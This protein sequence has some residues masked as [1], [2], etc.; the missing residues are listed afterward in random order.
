M[1]ELRSGSPE[2]AGMRPE[3]IELIRE[4]GAQWVSAGNSQ[5]LAVL[6]ARRGVICLQGA[7]G[8]LTGAPHAPRA[9]PDAMFY[10]ASLVKPVTAAIAMMLVEEG[11][12]GLT[13]PVE[14]YIPEV[15]GEGGEDVLVQHL[16][17]HTSGIDEERAATL[18]AKRLAEGVDPGECPTNQHPRM[19]RQLGALYPI[20]LETPPGAAMSYAYQ[21][22]ELLGEVIRRVAG[23]PLVELFQR[24]IFGP[25][26]MGQTTLGLNAADEVRLAFDFDQPHFPRAFSGDGFREAFAVPNPAGCLFGNAQDYARFAQMLLNGGCYGETRLL[27]RASVAQM[28]RNQIPGIGTSIMGKRYPEASWSYGLGITQTE[29]WRWFDATLT[30][31]GCYGHSGMGGTH[32]WVDPIHDIVGVYLSTGLRFDSERQERHRDL[33]LFQNLVTAAVED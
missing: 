19:H 18:S 25:L 7:W 13:R 11:G 12:L 14:F 3:Q 24:R 20:R 29:R 2:E 31:D 23:I 30:P 5:A 17:T 15:G 6:V 9:E 4:R 32:F 8:T 22:Y 26:G 21:N 10:L 1:I 33:D 28:T 27:R 16:L